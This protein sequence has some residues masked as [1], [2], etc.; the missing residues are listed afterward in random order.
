MSD[1]EGIPAQVQLTPEP[2][3]LTTS[4]RWQHS[5]YLVCV[6][7]SLLVQSPSLAWSCLKFRFSLPYLLDTDQPRRH[8]VLIGPAPLW[9]G[10]K[11][12]QMSLGWGLCDFLHLAVEWPPDVSGMVRKT[13]WIK[14]SYLPGPGSRATLHCLAPCC[15]LLEL[16]VISTPVVICSSSRLTRCPQLQELL[17][18]SAG[19]WLWNESLGRGAFG[20]WADSRLITGA[21][22]WKACQLLSLAT[23]YLVFLHQSILFL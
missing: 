21:V 23:R 5:N 13:A 18:C 15:V 16:G 9:Q 7:H 8:L 19:I 12:A 17:P 20:S 11:K 4:Q 1:G 6:G 2:T 14:A 22:L 3:L 10:C